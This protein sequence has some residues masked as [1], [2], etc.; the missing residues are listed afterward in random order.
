MKKHINQTNYIIIPLLSAVLITG[1]GKEKQRTDYVAKVNNAYL[2]REELSTMVDTAGNKYYKSEIIRNWV[3]QE[4]L[5]QEAEK[6]GILKDTEYQKLLNQS[7]RELASALLLQKHYEDEDVSYELKDI[8]AYYNEHRDDFRLFYEGYLLNII[9]FNNEDNAVQFRSTVLESDW[10]RA[11]NVYMGDSTIVSSRPSAL[12]YDFQINPQPLYRIV[13]D[14]NLG[15]VS[16]V[17]KDSN[18]IYQV[19]Q[20]ENKYNKGTIPPLDI[21]KSR[22]VKQFLADKK[23]KLIQNYIRDLYSNNDIEVKN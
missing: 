5:Y 13:Q 4:V 6:E 16:I 11:L 8:E 7:E 18:H 17:I 23:E 22:V 14:L 15:E 21:I 10:N 20:L 12:L 9:S 1:C 2:S 19:A 3:N